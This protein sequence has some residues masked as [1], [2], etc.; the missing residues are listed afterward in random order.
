MRHWPWILPLL[1][2]IALIIGFLAPPGWLMLAICIPALIGA[3]LSAVHHAEVIAHRIGEPFGT[4][5]LALAV[6]AIEVSLMVALMLSGGPDS[7]SLP[8]DTLFATIMIIVNG[9]VGISL[10]VGGL[11]H[12]E[13][14]FRI[15]GT[16]P[17]LAALIALSVL[18][19]VLPAY[20]TSTPG[21]TYSPL[22]LAFAAVA[23][24]VMWSVFIFGQT[25]KH[26]DYFLA[27]GA[28]SE[29]HAPPPSVATAWASFGLLIAALVA[30][31][32]LA[33]ALS[34][35]IEHGI[36]AM[37][38]PKTA[39]GIAIALLVLLPEAWAAI[40]AARANRLQTSMNLAL[41]SALATIGLTV[42]AVAL[43]ASILG[44]P[45]VLGLGSKEIILLLTSFLVGAITLGNGRTNLMQGAV[46]LVLFAAFLFLALV[47]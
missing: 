19:L 29:E 36:A 26:R 22:Q 24:L 4:L 8:R 33:K 10:L 25:I 15:E 44:F 39:I 34:P 27:P 7:A 23:S 12:H 42:P 28:E 18:T 21:P 41:G 45:L 35:A 20:T 11:R 9:V 37:G 43:A 38:A 32:G 47:P 17:A 6:T 31:V 30:V 13:Q 16:G 1:G 5:V 46:H 14:T 3:V 40:R 2:W